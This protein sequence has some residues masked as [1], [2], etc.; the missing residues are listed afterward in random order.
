[1]GNKIVSLMQP[2]QTSTFFILSVGR[3][4]FKEGFVC[5]LIN[6]NS[7]VNYL[8]KEYKQK[9]LLCFRSGDQKPKHE[10]IV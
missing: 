3:K 6:K 7:N 10:K 5:S 9:F 1:M 2:T 8:K 4:I